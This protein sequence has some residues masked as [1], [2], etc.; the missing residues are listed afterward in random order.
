MN[1]ISCLKNSHHTSAG[2]PVTILTHPLPSCHHSAQHSQH[3][4]LKP[5]FDH[6]TPQ[7]KGLQRFPIHLRIRTKHFYMAYKT[8]GPPDRGASF[9]GIMLPPAF[10]SP[11]SV[12]DFPFLK[13]YP[14]MRL[15][16][17]GASHYFF[18]PVCSFPSSLLSYLLLIF[19]ILIRNRFWHISSSTKQ[20]EHTQ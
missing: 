11:A 14:W 12:S 7:L 17:P 20:I 15:P 6:V 13:S 1:L 4:M 5:S 3:E 8:A 2:L 16:T 9:S 19:H 18:S 10:S